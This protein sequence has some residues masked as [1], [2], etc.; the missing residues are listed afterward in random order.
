MAWLWSFFLALSFLFPHITWAEE[1]IDFQIRSMKIGTT[2]LTVEIADTPE[3]QSRGLMFRKSL[4]EG[5]GMLFIFPRERPQSFWMKNTFIPLDI[6]FFDKSK[7]LIDIQQMEA[8]GSV[9]EVPKSYLSKAPA[10]YAL[11]VP[12]GWFAKMKVK[13]GAVF[14]LD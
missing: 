12:Q 7:K 9:M 6:G 11:E 13:E 14:H 5:H 1:K 8:V 4:K 10:M 2:T 3:R